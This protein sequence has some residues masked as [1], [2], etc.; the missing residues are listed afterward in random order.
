MSIKKKQRDY[1]AEYRR[2]IERGLAK[3]NTLSQARVH[4]KANEKHIKQPKPINDESFQ[5]G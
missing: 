5:I 4:P 2:R 3:G 1:K